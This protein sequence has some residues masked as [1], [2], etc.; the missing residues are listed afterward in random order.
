MIALLDAGHALTHALHD[1]CSL[2][3]QDCWEEALW[4]CVAT[5]ADKRSKLEISRR[6][7]EAE[8]TMAVERVGVCVAQCCGYNLRAGV[9]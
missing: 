7:L 2:V 9:S 1:A 3:A 5:G 8:L 6:E 4:V